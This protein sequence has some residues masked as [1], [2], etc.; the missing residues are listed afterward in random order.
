M[1]NQYGYQYTYYFYGG[2]GTTEND[3]KMRIAFVD[4][5]KGKFVNHLRI[6]N[7]SKAA[8]STGIQIGS[9]VEDIEK[10]YENQ[11]NT[12]LTDDNKIVVGFSLRGLHFGLK[13]GKV[14]TIDLGYLIPPIDMD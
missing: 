5:G 14:S 13:D 11:I 12:E 9:T 1:Q 7:D 6:Q 3:Y 4:K 8:L 2:N 10:T